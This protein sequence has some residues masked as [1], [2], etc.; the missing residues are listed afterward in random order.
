MQIQEHCTLGVGGDA[1]EAQESVRGKFRLELLRERERECVVDVVSKLSSVHDLES[2]NDAS[3]RRAALPKKTL[4][5]FPNQTR[6]LRY[7]C[8]KLRNAT[9]DTPPFGRWACAQAARAAESARGVR[10]QYRSLDSTL[11]V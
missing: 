2:S 5:R 1:G 6:D 10:P 11:G 9:Q 3:S 8:Q 4:D 7:E